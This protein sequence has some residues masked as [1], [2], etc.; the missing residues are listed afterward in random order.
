MLL[1]ASTV[2][3]NGHGVILMGKP[4][5]GKSDLALRLVEHAEREFLG[6]PMS[7]AL[8]ADDQ[9]EI[10]V[11]AGKLWAKP[12]LA[13]QGLLEVRGLGILSVPYATTVSVELVVH[14]KD[15]AEIERMP[16][17]ESLRTVLAGITI[18]KCDIDPRLSGATAR[19]KIGLMRALGLVNTI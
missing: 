14:L 16:D 8:V 15:Q 10:E 13:L 5:S 3:L 6:N 18:A 9:V 4:G 11:R 19:V 7:A 17:P 1:H 2:S 12:P